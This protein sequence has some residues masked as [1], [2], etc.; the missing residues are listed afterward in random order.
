MYAF[1]I[2]SCTLSVQSHV[3]F[4]CRVMIQLYVI[5]MHGC[6]QLQLSAVIR[7]KGSESV[8]L[9]KTVVAQYNGINITVKLPPGK[10]TFENTCE[11]K[12]CKWVC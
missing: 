7:G 10:L 2:E 12:Y 6:T 8:V 11:H 3:R 5:P 9:P 4:P 1:R